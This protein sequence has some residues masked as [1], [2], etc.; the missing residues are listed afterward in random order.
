MSEFGKY[1]VVEGHDATGKSTQVDILCR[2]LDKE[3][4]ESVKIEEP[5]GSPISDELRTIIKNGDLS[6]DG[7]TNLLLFTAARHETYRQ[8]IE[9]ALENG[10]WVVAARNWISTLAYQGAGEG[11]DSDEIL[12]MTQRFTSEKYLNPDYLS[13]L[14]L[15]D[16]TERRRRIRER[17]LL[18]NPDTFEGKDEQFQED[19][20][21]G[22]LQ[23]VEDRGI[24]V[25]D[26]SP[27]AD[28]VAAEIWRQVEPLT[29]AA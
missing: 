18:L 10:I 3:G 28:E 24:S 9:P 25:I 26:A 1:A 11:I 12:E 20:H 23:I 2:E 19:V 29:E 16:E 21:N 8:I 4:I 7:L 22:Y 27:S 5:A 14:V 6:R 15:K 17:G 13:V